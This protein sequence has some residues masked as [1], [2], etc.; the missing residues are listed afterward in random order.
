M[1]LIGESTA[2]A[3]AIW[4]PARAASRS[5]TRPPMLC[6]MTTVEAAVPASVTTARTS[7]AQMSRL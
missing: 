7:R 1:S 4:D 6:P 2:T 5:V 3:P